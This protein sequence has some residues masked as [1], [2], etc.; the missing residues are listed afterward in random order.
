[1]TTKKEK[2][3]FS[4][5][6][7]EQVEVENDDE[8]ICKMDAMLSLYLPDYKSSIQ[9][10]RLYQ[11]VQTSGSDFSKQYFAKIK[12]EIEETPKDK[13]KDFRANGE[14]LDPERTKTESTLK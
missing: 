13:R 1:M 8:T 12:S 5:Y 3:K 2:E 7:L 11:R 10:L 14:L 4:T 9:R 6:L